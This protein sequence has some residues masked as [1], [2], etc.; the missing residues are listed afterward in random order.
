MTID[1]VL[2]Q[3]IVNKM[4][5]QIPY[6][7]NMMD[8]HGYVIASGDDTRINTL[9]V[10]ALNAIEQKKTLP[11]DRSFGQHGQ[12]GINMPV[13]FDQKIVGVIGIT[14]DP[15]KVTPLASLLR[16]ATELLLSQNQINLREKKKENALNRFLYQWSQVSSGI[17][18]KT[19]LLLEASQLSIDVLK[20]RTAIAVELHTLPMSLL[21]PTDFQLS[22][23]AST[24]IVLTTQTTTINRFCAYCQKEKISIGIGSAQQNIGISVTQAL[25]TIKISHIFNRSD[26]IQFSQVAFI[27]TLLKSH[28]SIAE[29]MQKFQKTSQSESGLDLIKTLGMYIR[30]SGNMAQTAKAMHIHRNTLGYRLSKIHDDFNLDP[31][32]FVELFELYLGY[33]YYKNANYQFTQHTT[34][35]LD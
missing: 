12:P 6:N 28:L 10:G 8:E 32:D 29:I 20:K 33:I 19:D 27:N 9:H 5:A 4:M 21:D 26:L 35:T 11:M 16:I 23:S 34:K 3:S 31:H 24:I 1:P 15:D 18:A 25:E 30:H 17:E 14:G 7:I 13:F 2:A 22:L